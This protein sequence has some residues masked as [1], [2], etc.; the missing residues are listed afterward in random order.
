MSASSDPSPSSSAAAAVP[1]PL[2]A[3]QTH[4]HHHHNLHLSTPPHHAYPPAAPPPSPA[5]APRDYRKGNWTLHETLILITAK[6][7]DDDR[8]AGGGVAMA[9]P[10]SPPTP[11]SAEQRWKW[12]ENY[13]WINGCLRSQNQCND[14]WDNLLRDYKKVRDYEARRASIAAA[15][16]PVDAAAPAAQQQQPQTPLPSYWTMERHDRKERNLPTN[17][18]PEVYDALLDVLSRR[19]AR[20]GGAA[21][22]PGAPAQLALPPPPPPPPPSPPKPLLNQQ[23]QQQQQKHHH[24]HPQP[25]A[26]LQLPPPL[27][28]PSSVPSA[29]SVSAEEE[30]T[31]SSESGSD[32]LGGMSGGG[33]GDGDEPEAKRRR[34]V[35]RLGSSVVRSATVLARTL[36]ACEDRRERRHREVLELEERRLRLEA[37]RNEVRRQGFAGLVAAVNGLSGAIHALVSDHHGRSGDS[38]R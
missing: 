35:E 29:T 6:R 26:L 19:A 38:S 17:L 33:G 2:A 15:A 10:S 24:L 20:R 30:M 25:P 31:G 37:E 3:Y 7:L 5:S 21:I 27:P 8:R 18:A 11:R 16:P 22:A 9:G 1:S 14:K 32:G 4:P 36:V 13:C 23:Q 12:V 34:R 28:H